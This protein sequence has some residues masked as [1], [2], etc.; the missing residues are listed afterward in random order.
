MHEGEL[1]VEA[2]LAARRHSRTDSLWHSGSGQRNSKVSVESTKLNVHKKPHH[3]TVRELVPPPPAR[4][5]IAPLS[6][7]LATAAVTAAHCRLLAACCMR[8]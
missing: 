7:S 5:A 2:K 4:C 8:L 6:V 1:S 3:S